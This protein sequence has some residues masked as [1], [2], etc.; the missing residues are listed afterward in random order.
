M[1]NIILN[2]A[3]SVTRLHP[4]LADLWPVE[5]P[6]VLHLPWF[7]FAV[8]VAKLRHLRYRLGLQSK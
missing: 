7:H 6:I 8:R 4:D 2:K 1:N 3:L 5:H